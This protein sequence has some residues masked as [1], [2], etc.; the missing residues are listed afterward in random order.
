MKI[1]L[2]IFSSNFKVGL[3]RF[4]VFELQGDQN[5][6]KDAITIQNVVII[7]PPVY[8]EA[9]SVKSKK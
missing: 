2:K 7:W 8:Y 4:G 1:S 3:C 6:L 5:S 9:V